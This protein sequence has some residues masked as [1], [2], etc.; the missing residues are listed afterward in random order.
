MRSLWRKSPSKPS[1]PLVSGLGPQG[2]RR[3]EVL[4]GSVALLMGFATRG[5]GALEAAAVGTVMSP[6]TTG[7]YLQKVLKMVRDSQF[8][9][10]PYDSLVELKLL[11]DGTSSPIAVFRVDANGRSS[12]ELTVDD[13]TKPISLDAPAAT[14]QVI[15][16]FQ[17]RVM[18]LRTEIATLR[19][20][21][22]H[23]DEKT[24]HQLQHDE[25]TL[26]AL[27][28]FGLRMLDPSHPP[29]PRNAN[30]QWLPMPLSDRFLDS[31]QR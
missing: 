2:D 3:R 4:R 6:Q 31:A 27:S 1:F 19:Q 28:W 23:K 9:A 20:Q 25:A 16:A 17:E 26:F 30:D 24:F 11:K 13:Q 8:H 10:V 14:A 18:N 5:F 12:A 29:A 22:L 7:V 21:D 15:K